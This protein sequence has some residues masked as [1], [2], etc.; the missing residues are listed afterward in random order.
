MVCSSQGDS[1][2][3]TSIIEIIWIKK[4]SSVL[5]KAPYFQGVVLV[6]KKYMVPSIMGKSKT[7]FGNKVMAPL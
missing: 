6:S 2:L 5:E 7:S 4:Y 1:Y 3:P